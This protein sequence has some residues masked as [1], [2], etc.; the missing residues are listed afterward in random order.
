MHPL[1]PRAEQLIKA[2]AKRAAEYSRLLGDKPDSTPWV[3]IIMLVFNEY[4]YLIEALESVL[5]QTWPFYRVTLI[6][7]GSTRPTTLGL[8]DH[9]RT[10]P[11]NALQVVATG[12]P[13]S[14]V[15]A[16]N[17]GAASTDCPY[18]LM[19]DS[20]DILEPT[21]VEI[22]LQSLRDKPRLGAVYCDFRLFGA[23]CGDMLMPEYNVDKLLTINCMTVTSLYRRF[24]WDLVGGYTEEM[25]G[26]YED[27]E[28]WIKLAEAGWYAQRIP[29]FLLNVRIKP[30]SRNAGAMRKGGL[31][32]ER[33]RRLHPEMYDPPRRAR[34]ARIWSGTCG[35]RPQ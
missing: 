22:M 17:L 9:L 8:L 28:F 31:L 1:H 29:Q 2:F 33:I 14:V 23:A 24:L 3:D 27:W 34:I 13:I 10:V 16:R 20:D 21:C 7:N 6:D 25:A 15:R 18:I 26:G 32:T 35:E 4:E 5:A 12:R 19:F 11:S 30:Q